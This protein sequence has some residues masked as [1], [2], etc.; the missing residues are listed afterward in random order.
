MY[1]NTK[2]RKYIDKLIAN[3]LA[4]KTKLFRRNLA[5][6]GIP[7]KIR[8]VKLKPSDSFLSEIGGYANLDINCCYLIK[9]ARTF[10]TLLFNSSVDV[11][12]TDCR[13]NVIQTFINLSPDSIPSF[14]KIT[15]N[16]IIFAPNVIKNHNIKLTDHV[17]TH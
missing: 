9:H 7:T 1:R 2:E 14:L 13:H 4:R 8:V 17:Y 12:A 10:D 6:N 15:R 16:I 3:S 11:I 5:I